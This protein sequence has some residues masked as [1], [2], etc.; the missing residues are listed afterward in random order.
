[1]KRAPEAPPPPPPA[2]P[3]VVPAKPEALN[4]KIEAVKKRIEE[5]KG[6]TTGANPVLP[7]RPATI[8]P[9]L[10]AD[11]AS[12]SDAVNR[13]LE[14]AQNKE[15][16]IPPTPSPF[17]QGA[18]SAPPNPFSQSNE[19]PS[20]Y[21]S[22]SSANHLAA[23]QRAA[24]SMQN[25]QA[26]TQQ[27]QE[28]LTRAAEMINAL[29]ANKQYEGTSDYYSGFK[30]DPKALA[31]KN[32]Q[33]RQ[34]RSRVRT[35]QARRGLPIWAL[36]LLALLAVGGAVWYAKPVELYSIA[37]SMFN[38][39]APATIDQM[40]QAG[41]YAEAKDALEKKRSTLKE[42]DKIAVLQDKLDDVYI[43]LAG[44]DVEDKNY[45]EAI[46][47]L[48]KITKRS[49]HYKDARK[50]IRDYKKASQEDKPGSSDSASSKT[51]H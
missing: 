47:E 43:K 35:M 36:A 33:A 37:M 2:P 51:S 17:Q 30:V 34:G 38:K 10:Q 39:Q 49:K 26:A 48:Q 50:L 42:P 44:K 24:E 31:E 1:A 13:L 14:A 18:Q 20:H 45:D 28:P 12:L 15:Q 32:K 6:E 5:L 40:I 23:A 46:K 9:E 8:Q 16:T 19:P 25:M 11:Q 21:M 41:R 7:S 27:Q 29:K 3:P 22:Q 4:R